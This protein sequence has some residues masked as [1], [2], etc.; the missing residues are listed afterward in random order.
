[1]TYKYDPFPL[2]VNPTLPLLSS[3]PHRLLPQIAKGFLARFRRSTKE[4]SMAD[5]G[6]IDLDGGVVVEKRGRGHPLGSKNKPKVAI[7]E[8]SSSSPAKRRPGH[9][10]GRKN[11]AK[12]STSQI[13]EPLDV[14]VAHLNPPQ[15]ST[16]V[17][18][19]FFAL[20]GAQCREQ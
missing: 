16:G 2:Y 13:N 10:L 9:P 5:I 12:A 14:S 3:P 18:F 20:G 6:I 7:M 17:V 19:S 11:K 1:M 4:I 15:P 8:A